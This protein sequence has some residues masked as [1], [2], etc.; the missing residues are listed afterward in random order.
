[1]LVLSNK[2][3]IGMSSVVYLKCGQDVVQSSAP[4]HANR[5]RTQACAVGCTSVLAAKGL[6]KMPLL[7]AARGP[8]DNLI[9]KLYTK[10]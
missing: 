2:I 7:V 6:Q 4:V 8:V 1:V 3:T 10:S 5:G 9:S